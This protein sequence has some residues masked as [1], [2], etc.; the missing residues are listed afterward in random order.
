MN[1]TEGTILLKISRPRTRGVDPFPVLGTLFGTGYGPGRITFEKFFHLD[2]VRRLQGLETPTY[3][4][5]CAVPC[6]SRSR[7]TWLSP[8][9]SAIDSPLP[10]LQKAHVPTTTCRAA[11]F[12]K[13]TKEPW[14][15]NGHGRL[16]WM[17]GF[18]SIVYDGHSTCIKFM[19][20]PIVHSLS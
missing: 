20:H 3:L 14:P 15:R 12:E 8:S 4:E 11:A 9:R 6:P 2:E 16:I 17:I 1:K 18:S 19:V 10:K 7:P 5:L 13:A